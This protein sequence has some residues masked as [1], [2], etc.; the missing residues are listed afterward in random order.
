MRT[1]DRQGVSVQRLRSVGCF[2]SMALAL[3]GCGT[4]AITSASGPVQTGSYVG[5]TSQGLPISFT[6]TATSV[7][8]IQFGW[9]ATCADGQSHSN[10]IL[11][12]GTSIASGAFAASGTLDTGASSSVSGKV[13]GENASGTLSRSGPSAFG[14]NCTDTGVAWTARRSG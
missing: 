5:A 13:V 7:Q 10:T 8:S 3:A 6:V 4:S 12:G 11:L 2:A 14:T 1:C 9:Q